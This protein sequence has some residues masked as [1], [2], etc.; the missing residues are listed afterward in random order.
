MT[1]RGGWK[2]LERR[3]DPSRPNLELAAAVGADAAKT[4]LAAIGA[5]GALETAD[6]GGGV[7]HMS[8]ARL[9][10]KYRQVVK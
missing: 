8:E 9:V 2:P 1:F 6:P 4:V 5:E 3:A 7:R 10:G